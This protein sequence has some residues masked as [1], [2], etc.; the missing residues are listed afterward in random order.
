MQEKSAQKTAEKE[1]GKG[2]RTKFIENFTQILRN[3]QF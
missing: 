3:W 2:N 1:G